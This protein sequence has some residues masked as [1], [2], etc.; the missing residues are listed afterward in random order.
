M[1]DENISFFID[2][3]D[4]IE[5]KGEEDFDFDFDLNEILNME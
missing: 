5:E 3:T 2:D 1:V 4:T